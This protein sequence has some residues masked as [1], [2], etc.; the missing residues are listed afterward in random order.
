MVLLL[1]SRLGRITIKTNN[2]GGGVDEKEDF[3]IV[4]FSSNDGV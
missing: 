4:I 3:V 2:L 1:I